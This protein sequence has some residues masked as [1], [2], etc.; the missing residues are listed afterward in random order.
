[1]CNGGRPVTAFPRAFV[2]RLHHGDPMPGV[3]LPGG[4]AVVFDDSESGISS[5]APSVAD[6]CR[7]Y[8]GARIEWADEAPTPAAPGLP[9]QRPCTDPRHTG[10]LRT[11]LGCAGPDPATT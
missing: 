10:A 2:L 5:G 6:L 8:P 1:M 7:G 11:Q 4:R 9:A 3:E